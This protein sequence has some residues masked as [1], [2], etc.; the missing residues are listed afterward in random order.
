MRK[1]FQFDSR[2]ARKI[3]DGVVPASKYKKFDHCCVGK[4]DAH[5]RP[6]RI[7]YPAVVMQLIDKRQRGAIF[8][9][10]AG[11]RTIAMDERISLFRGH[12]RLLTIEGHIDAPFILA[13]A[14]RRDAVD[15]QLARPQVVAGGDCRVSAEHVASECK[16]AGRP[17][18]S[19]WCKSTA[20]EE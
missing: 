9:C 18:R 6:G 20:M 2:V 16:C 14:S 7:G 15:H 11:I 1:T 3:D 8:V 12:P 4:P 13:P 19:R 10:P 17:A 5:G